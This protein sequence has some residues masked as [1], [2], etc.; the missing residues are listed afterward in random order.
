MSVFSPGFGKLLSLG[1]VAFAFLLLPP[2]ARC[3]EPATETTAPPRVAPLERDLG[4]GLAYFRARE[5][6]S[7]LPGAAA[8]PGPLVLDLRFVAVRD[9]AVTAL[10]AWLKFRATPVAPVFVLFNAETAAPVRDYL[11]A[12][13]AHPGLVTLGPAAPGFAPDLA[14][15]AT[16]EEDRAAYD[17]LDR[18]AVLTTLIT[19]NADKPRNDEA[20]LVRERANP[21]ADPT[22]PTAND[23]PAAEF[24]EKSTPAPA[25]PPPPPVDYTL[26]RAIQLHRALHALKRL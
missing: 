15:D 9:S 5:L 24:A 11:A 23:D 26:Q 19:E 12:E 10:E 4:E 8:K 2:A 21:P 18:G 16:A 22:S 13:K 3:A 25:A 14:I 20:A 17:A 1:S 6:P 7:D